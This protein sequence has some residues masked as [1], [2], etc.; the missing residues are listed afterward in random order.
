MANPITKIILSAVDRTKAAF[1]SVKGGLAS[2]G[3]AA[4][5][6]SGTLGS[7]FVGLSVAGFVGKIKQTIDAMDEA[8][9]A[10]MRA[11]TN[12]EDFSALQYVGKMSGVED[13]EKSLIALVDSLD[14]AKSGAGPTADAFKSL[15][16]DPAQFTD[17]SDA[18]DAIAD[19]FAT[20]PDGVDKTAL[21][22]ELFGKKVGPDLVPLLNLGRSGIRAFKDEAAAFGVVIGPDAERAAAQFNDNMDK[23]KTAASG[24]GVSVANEMLPGL[25]EVTRLMADAAKQG[26]L[27]AAAMA[28]VRFAVSDVVTD[29]D[30]AATYRLAEAQKQLNA[31]RKDGFEEDHKRVAMLRTIIPSLQVLANE[32]NRVADSAAASATA[33]K[34]AVEDQKTA[35]E[36]LKKS[37]DEQIKDA[38]RLQSALQSAF[39]A[40][41]KAETDYLRQ[42]K[43][44]RAEANAPAEVS[45]DPEAQAQARLGAIIALMKLQREASSASLEDVQAQAAAVRDLA[46]GL[47]D[48]A[49]KTDLMKQAS[50]AEAAALEKAAAEEGARA[51]G[52]AELLRATEAQAATLQQSLDG[53]GKEVSVEVKPGAQMEKTI[54]GLERVAHLIEHIKQLGPITASTTGADSVEGL[55]RTAALQHGRRN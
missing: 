38:E 27:T 47:S 2:I 32:E 51:A 5:S 42:A 30:V 10:A 54:Q 3:S 7:I 52:Q 26:G 16:I 48:A 34:K 20:M 29:N 53:I 13:M 25:N 39:S 11:G 23:L 46:G 24:L 35:N 19:Q 37:T 21:A 45:D 1:T 44:L 49:L 15:G 17:S 31:L 14:R 36:D 8:G 18:L 55:L 6:L 41:I 12:V 43:K 4:T 40:S 9:E 28:A 33:R 50:L 22:I